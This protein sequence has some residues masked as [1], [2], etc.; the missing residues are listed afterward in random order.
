VISCGSKLDCRS[1]GTSSSIPAVVG[2]RPYRRLFASRQ[3]GPGALV[4]QHL[5]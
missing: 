3:V 5:L 4:G 1:R 2:K